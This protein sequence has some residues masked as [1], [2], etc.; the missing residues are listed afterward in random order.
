MNAHDVQREVRIL[1]NKEKA[2]FLQR[3]FKTA[4]GEY[5]EGDL[6]LG[7]T[8]PQARIIA[9]KYKDLSLPEIEKLLHSK[10]HEERLIALLILVQSFN[11]R[12]FDQKEIVD[13]YLK[14]TKYINNWDLVDVSAPNILGMYLLDRD[15]SVLYKLS[16]SADLWEKRIS[17]LSTLAF[18][19]K[20]KEY[21]DTFNIADVLLEDQHDLIHKAV[22]WMLREVGKRVSQETEEEFLRFRYKNMPRTMLRYAIERF[23]ADKRKKY[24]LGEF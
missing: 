7:L 15:R 22:G 24:L 5:A 8:V 21:I 1:A 12:K 6:F 19:V 9:R 2:T 14:N 23:D 3:F 16:K 4:K 17:I 20:Q 18:I 13:V 10:F 11:A